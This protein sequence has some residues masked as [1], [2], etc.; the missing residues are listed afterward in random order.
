MR[1]NG[2]DLGAW[3]AS[4][5]ARTAVAEVG[6]HLRREAWARGLAELGHV[7]RAYTATLSGSY[8]DVRGQQDV[9]PELHDDPLSYA[10]SQQ[11]GEAIRS[12]A[13]AGLIFDSLRHQGGV[14]TVAYRPLIM[15]VTQAD[16]FEITVQAATK[17]MNA[18]RL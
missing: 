17:Q 13:G 2:P 15:N 5:T 8:L 11:S 18:R 9:R 12:A 6:H 1:F 16:H 4:A 10:A 7:Y 14:N 3:Y